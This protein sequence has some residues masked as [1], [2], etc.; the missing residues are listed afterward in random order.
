MLC[1]IFSLEKPVFFNLLYTE[2]LSTLRRSCLRYFNSG[3]Y[4]GYFGSRRLENLLPPSSLRYFNSGDALWKK[5]SQPRIRT[6]ML[7][8]L[9]K[10]QGSCACQGLFYIPK[11]I[12]I[13]LTS[14]FDFEKALKACCQKMLET[15]SYSQYLSI[16]QKTR[17]ELPLPID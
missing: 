8:G 9:E 1:H 16:A 4:P 5:T 7:D 12:R 2:L 15:C 11:I 3:I 10:C 13:E 6:E 17:A 14:H